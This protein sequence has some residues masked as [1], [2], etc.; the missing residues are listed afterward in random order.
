V[1]LGDGRQVDVQL[2]QR[3]NVVLSKEDRED[4]GGN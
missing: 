3:F 4:A 2:D 1:T